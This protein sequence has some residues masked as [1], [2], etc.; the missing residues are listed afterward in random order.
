MFLLNKLVSIDAAR[1]LVKDYALENDL[2][3]SL[4]TEIVGLQKRRL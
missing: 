3:S 4:N 2:R 1:V